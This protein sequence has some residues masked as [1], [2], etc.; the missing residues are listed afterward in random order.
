MT[1]EIV[2][3]IGITLSVLVLLAT[4]RIAADA[5][6]AAALTAVL[7]F[8]VPTDAGWQLGLIT[9]KQGLAGFS[10]DGVLTVGVLFIIV[11]GLRETGGIDWIASRL[12]G[13]PKSERSAVVRV[14]IPVFGLS[15]FLNNTP[16]VAMM[17]PAIQ[18]WAKKLHLPHSKLLIPLSYASILGGT[19]SLIGSSTN[20]VIA[21]L[22]IAQTDLAPLGMFDI[23][24]VGLPTA[25]IGLIFLVLAGPHLLP[26]RHRDSGPL[27]DT[28]EYVLELTIPTSSS[29]ASK[30]VEQ[31]GLRHLPGCFLI[32]I[33]R[34]D[35]IISAVGPNQK[36]QVGDRLVFAGIVDSI[37]ELVNTRGLAL[38]SN[39]VF[40]LDSP[41]Y[42]R[43]LFEAVVSPSSPA[44]GRSIK[45][46]Q[47]RNVYRGAVIAVARNGERVRG[48]IGD[49][50]VQPGDLLLIESDPGFAARHNNARDF[51]LVRTLEDSTPR[52]HTRAPIAI[53][54][55]VGM[56]ALAAFNVYSML[57]S[58]LLA[59]GFMVLTRCCTI[60]EARQSIDWSVLVVIGAALGIGAAMDE[61]GAADL[62]AGSMLTIA[63]THPWVVLL[64]IYLITSLLTEFIS[65]NAAVALLFPIA[66]AT[67]ESLGVNFMPFIIAIM[68]AGSASFATPVGYQTNLM[69]YGPGGYRFSDFLRIGMPMNMITALTAVL[70]T[71]L[72]FPFA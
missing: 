40:K 64:A 49:I 66:Q 41:R 12:L 32:E 25:V 30:T 57:V 69:V 67:A 71:P 8:P 17:I 13:R 47:F 21:G 4:T 10:N 53:A 39:Q 1:V 58:A 11:T 68:M 6:L 51:L 2:L 50:V 27:V 36:L 48:R 26:D 46:S 60:T 19:C 5:I 54:I 23:T 18:D 28:R 59:A 45:Q 42:R 56:V 22:V 52:R 62:L 35:E 65:N 72:V 14:M 9:A 34:G 61:T 7:A 3:V 70:I 43:R 15:G 37:K 63:G 29:I 55:L 38:A 31:A 24:W 20:L 44:A 16:V 33:E